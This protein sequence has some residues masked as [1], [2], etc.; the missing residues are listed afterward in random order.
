MQTGV[1]KDFGDERNNVEP[2]LVDA[3]QVAASLETSIEHGLSNEEADKRLKKYGPNELQTKGAATVWELINRHLFNF[4]QFLFMGAMVMLE[5]NMINFIIL[6]RRH[7]L[8]FG[9][10]LMRE[11]LLLSLR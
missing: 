2:Y 5:C 9:N 11:S 3:E 8:L 10:L 6:Y 1:S 4:L 7:L